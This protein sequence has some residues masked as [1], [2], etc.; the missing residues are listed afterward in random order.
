MK[1]KDT[2]ASFLGSNS[3]TF[4]IILLVITQL[5][6]HFLPFERQSIAPDNF[7]FLVRTRNEGVRSIGHYFLKYPHRPLNH[8][9]LDLQGKFADDSPVK[10]LWLVFLSSLFIQLGVFFLLSLL[11][12]DSFLAFIASL[13]YCAM[14]NKLEVYHN[15][16]FFNMDMA[17][18]I[19][20]LILAFFFKF[21]KSQKKLYLFTSF[22]LYTIVIFWYE[23]GFFIP[24]ILIGYGLFYRKKEAILGALCF[25]IP[26]SIYIILRITSVFGLG[27][28]STYPHQIG[29]SGLPTTL[30]DLAHNF[31]GR[32]MARSIIY[33]FYKFFSIAQPY[34]GI[35][36][37]TDIGFLL[38]IFAW[39]KN[40]KVLG[41]IEPRLLFL[42]SIIFASFLIPNS[43]NNYGGLAGRQLALPLIGVVIIFVW[44]L[45]KF[46]KYWSAVFLSFIALTLIICQGNSWAQ[47]V[48]CRI[49][50]AVYDTLKEKKQELVKA[51]NVVI[52]TKSFAENIPFTFIQ[53]DFNTLNTYYG[54]QAFEDWGLRSMV[55]L[56]TA[57][58]KKPVF[59]ATEIPQIEK[60]GYLK[61]YLSKYQA[62]R[63]IE[64]KAIELSLKSVIVI[65]YKDVYPQG[66]YNG[67]RTP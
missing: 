4:F 6:F 56:V 36:I 66:F 8:F 23:P 39:L 46:K 60:N 27:D 57:D 45:A 52:D 26:G 58:S 7:A 19:Y 61:F 28:I 15:S 10:G 18:G 2:M 55:R 29:F 1:I 33:G 41:L 62:Y 47:V 30:L 14:P 65:G 20:V 48:A 40:K 31:F 24:L 64:K 13:I 16:I 67:Q 53:R 44:G 17:M 32:Y 5:I 37:L 59:V 50:R 51:E 9:V 49:N 35:I 63:S 21:I 54:A 34:L 12:N 25:M 3:K 42:A 11:F 22:L 38:F 43:L